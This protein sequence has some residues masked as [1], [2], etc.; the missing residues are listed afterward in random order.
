MA[1]LYCAPPY[2]RIDALLI[3]SARFAAA[4]SAAAN[5]PPRTCSS[6]RVSPKRAAGAEVVPRR[7]RPILVMNASTNARPRSCRDGDK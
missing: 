5:A 7:M 6:C 3:A 2:S 1:R 4:L